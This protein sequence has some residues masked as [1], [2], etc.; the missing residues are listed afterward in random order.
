MPV[1]CKEFLLQGFRLLSPTA[2]KSSSKLDMSEFGSGDVVQN[3]DAELSLDRLNKEKAEAEA[4]AKEEQK[5]I[6]VASDITNEEDDG[7]FG[8]GGPFL[9]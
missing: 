6:A 9:M 7:S 5:I 1:L 2:P 3:E 8:A 4:K